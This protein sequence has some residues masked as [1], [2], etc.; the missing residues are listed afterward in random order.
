M[1]GEFFIAA[2]GNK[3]YR[4][5]KR[6]PVNRLFFIV[7]VFDFIT[8]PDFFFVVVVVLLRG[9]SESVVCFVITHKSLYPVGA[10]FI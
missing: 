5:V 9:I 10:G 6:L 8:C 4:V 2:L 1:G 3:I 7:R